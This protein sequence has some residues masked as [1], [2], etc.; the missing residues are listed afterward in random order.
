M[1]IKIAYAEKMKINILVVYLKKT[2]KYP[3]FL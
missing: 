3:T 1:E 2:I